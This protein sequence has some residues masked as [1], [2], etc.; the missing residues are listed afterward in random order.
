[1][2]RI[3]QVSTAAD[4]RAGLEIGKDVQRESGI[5]LRIG[6]E[7][8]VIDHAAGAGMT[9]LAG[10]KHE[11]D[12][13]GKLVAVTVQ[14]VHRLHQ[15]RG[16]SIVTAGMHAS[17][18]LAGKAEPGL[19]RHRQ[20]VHVAAQQNRATALRAGSGAA[21]RHDEAGCRRPAADPDIETTQPVEHCLGRQRQIEAELRLGMDA[22]TQC[23]RF[24]Q[25]LL[26]LVEETLQLRRLSHTSCPPDRARCDSDTAWQ[27]YT[28]AGPGLVSARR[29]TN[30]ASVIRKTS[31]LQRAANQ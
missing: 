17:G 15:H 28:R 22:P 5:G 19:L 6:V 25:Q 14:E 13:A 31:D 12:G 1:L 11:F 16:M 30:A 20:R 8:P 18:N 27:P 26:R 2:T 29:Q 3:V 9:L 7:Q 4:D 10:L 21:Q 24:R 23:D